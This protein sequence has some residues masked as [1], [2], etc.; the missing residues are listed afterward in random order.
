MKLAGKCCFEVTRAQK[1]KH[2]MFSHMWIL[3]SNGYLV[4]MGHKAREQIL[5]KGRESSFKQEGW[6][7]TD[8]WHKC[9]K[10]NTWGLE[11]RLSG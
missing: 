3:A 1:D 5:R 6:K 10:R 2:H 7:D 8:M 11:R 4:G 9:K